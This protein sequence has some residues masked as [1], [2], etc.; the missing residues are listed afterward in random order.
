MRHLILCTASAAV[1]VL[2]VSCGDDDGG[3]GPSGGG[4]GDS[5]Y[6]P[7]AVGNT[8][9]YSRSGTYNVDSVE[10]P[11][12][13]EATVEIVGTATHSQGWDV[14]VE[15]S[16]VSDTIQGLM[17]TTIVDSTYLW[18]DGDGLHGCPHL[19][20]TDSCWTVPFPLVEGNTWTFSTQPP[21]TGEVLS[22][23]VDVTVGAGSFEEC[24][25]M[26]TMCLEQ[27]NYSNTTDYAENVGMV[28]NVFTQEAGV[29]NTTVDMTL[30]SYQVQ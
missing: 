14:F 27:G 26:R 17:D 9:E 4:A 2:A 6:Y 22:M 7:L 5:V 15:V 30:E 23:D 12:S 1:L 24:A 19:G 25:E 18:R 10:H 28:R 13:G 20:D 21:V 11:V 8:W 3:T 16:T 29:Y